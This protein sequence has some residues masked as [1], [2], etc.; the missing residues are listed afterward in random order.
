MTIIGVSV[1]LA[2]LLAVESSS[3]VAHG[4]SS[5]ISVSEC[6]IEDVFLD[7][8]D[9]LLQIGR[10][11]LDD[12]LILL[13][14]RNEVVVFLQLLGKADGLLQVEKP[15]LSSLLVLAG[16]QLFVW[17][18]YDEVDHF[19]LHVKGHLF[20]GND[21][22]ALENVKRSDLFGLFG[23]VRLAFVSDERPFEGV[24]EDIPFLEAHEGPLGFENGSS[25]D[26]G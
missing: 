18:L 4:G 12:E 6:Q 10:L 8:L 20:F 5:A 25:D 26:C 24:D 14:F 22:H 1:V 21:P 13:D 9:N 11:I 2:A 23:V 19:L 3:F 16:I 15:L 17:L 7:L